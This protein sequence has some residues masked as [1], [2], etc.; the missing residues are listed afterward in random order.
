VEHRQGC[1]VGTSVADFSCLKSHFFIPVLTLLNCSGRERGS[2]LRPWLAVDRTTLSVER[3]LTGMRFSP[4]G[5]LEDAAD[6][7][8]RAE[9]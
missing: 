9:A 4:A 8:P 2:E 1:Q 7:R 6:C 3:S 5:S